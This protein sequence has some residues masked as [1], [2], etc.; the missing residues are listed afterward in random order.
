MPTKTNQI[1]IAWSEA[2]G[3][4][5]KVY[6]NN[7]VKHD[8]SS[9]FQEIKGATGEGSLSSRLIL[10]NSTLGTTLNFVPTS[11]ELKYNVNQKVIDQIL[12]ALP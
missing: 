6:E 1:E 7:G 2:S 3:F 12:E 5:A 11:K 4:E 8:I 9:I 10:G